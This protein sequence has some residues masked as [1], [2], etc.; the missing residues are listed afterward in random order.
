V[1]QGLREDHMEPLCRERVASASLMKEYGS[2]TEG[3]DRLC[4]LKN[5]A[6]SSDCVHRDVCR[7][8]L[9]TVWEIDCSARFSLVLQ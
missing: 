5:C 9:Q 8:M 1:L 7:Q 3:T 6:L 4:A 2:V